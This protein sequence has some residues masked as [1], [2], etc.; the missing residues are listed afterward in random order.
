MKNR[1]FLPLT[2]AILLSLSLLGGDAAAQTAPASPAASA[3]SSSLQDVHGLKLNCPVPLEAKQAVSVPGLDDL[4]VSRESRGAKTEGV[5]IN[6]EAW[7]MKDISNINLE[8]AANGAAD[9][10]SKVNGVKD[11]TRSIRKADVPGA[12]AAIRLSVKAFAQGKEIRAEGV[13]IV[14]GSRYWMLICNFES[15]NV[16]SIFIGETV[17]KSV[18]FD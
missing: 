16:R 6:L 14:K 9:S 18:R 7:E 5:E 13:F 1:P 8:G 15:A 10:I 12:D 17:V 11:L 3:V 4:L 2:S